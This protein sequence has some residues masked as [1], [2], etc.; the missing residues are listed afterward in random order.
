MHPR[1][2]AGFVANPRMVPANLGWEGSTSATLASAVNRSF[3]PTVTWDDLA[4]LR[5]RWRGPLIIKGVMR[6]DDARPLRRARRGRDHR[7]QP[8]RTPTRRRGR[9]IEALPAIADAVGDRARALPRQRHPPR[10]RHRQGPRP[11]RP[12]RADRPGADVR[13]RRG[14]RSRARGA[15]SRSSRTNCAWRSPLPV[16]RARRSWERT[17][18][19]SEF[20]EER[21]VRLMWCSRQRLGPP[22]TSVACLWH[23]SVV[24]GARCR[25]CAAAGV[26]CSQRALAEV[27][28]LGLPLR[29]RGRRV[30]V[31]SLRAFQRARGHC[32]VVGELRRVSRGRRRV[33]S[34]V[35]HHETKHEAPPGGFAVA[36]SMTPQPGGVHC[37]ETYPTD[38]PNLK[39]TGRI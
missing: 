15:R 24:G 13:A 1:W 7:L 12:R 36:P 11:R 29:S 33:G 28:V 21:A 10:H 26:P 3:D 18:R 30:G 25:G 37:G 19:A 17:P 23:V 14:G 34:L 35:C 4:D 22:A 39:R 2:S 38:G 6:A 31:Q 5:S 8:R 27:A 32:K 20:A 16:T 9:A